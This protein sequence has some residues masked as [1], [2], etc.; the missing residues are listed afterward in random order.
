MKNLNK[1]TKNELINNY[2]VG[3]EFNLGYKIIRRN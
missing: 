2:K 3:L 1:F